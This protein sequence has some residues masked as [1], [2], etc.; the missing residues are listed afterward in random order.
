MPVVSAAERRRHT[1]PNA[2]M[3]TLASPTLG[4]TGGLAMWSVEMDAGASGPEHA[5]DVEQ[6]WTVTRGAAEVRVGDAVHRVAEGDTLV[7]PAG[8]LRRVVAAP[9]GLRAIVAA[10]AGARATLPD[11]TDRGTPPWIA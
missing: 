8:E 2:V 4:G 11:G 3:S 6:V 1:T 5:F 9:A 7:L 10:P